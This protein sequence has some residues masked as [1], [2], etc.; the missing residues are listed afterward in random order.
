MPY[1]RNPSITSAL[2]HQMSE[3]PHPGFVESC[4]SSEIDLEV[5]GISVSPQAREDMKK[6]YSP[7]GESEADHSRP[8]G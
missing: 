1:G 3:F 8:S 5:R 4:K 7:S 6:R 2:T